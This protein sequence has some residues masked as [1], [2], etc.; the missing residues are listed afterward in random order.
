[1]KARILAVAP[2]GGH[3]REARIALELVSGSDVVY[4]TT[5]LPHLLETAS[6]NMIFIVDPHR[7]L[8]KYILNIVQSFAIYRKTTP[9]IIL[10]TGGGQSIALFLI[11]KILGCKTIFVE[12]GSRIQF[13]SKTGRLLYHFSD[14]FFIQS[15]N[16]F[17][18]YPKAKFLR[19][20]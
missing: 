18:F 10:S 20:M 3:L 2:G 9:E 1:L 17:A 6:P 7:S 4:V 5:R 8:H 13:P 16:L 14:H 19:V 12:S 15:P 11:G